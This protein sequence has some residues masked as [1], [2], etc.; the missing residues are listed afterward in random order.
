MNYFFSTTPVWQQKGLAIIR[1]ITGLFMVY[2]GWEVFDAGKMK[3]YLEWDQFQSPYSLFLVHLGKGSEFAG[4]LLLTLG[5]FTRW[6][7]LIIAVTMLYISLFVGTGKI[8]YQDQ[9]PFLF[10]L[11][12]LVFFFTGPGKYSIDHILFT[13]KNIT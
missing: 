1:I 4:G 10:V 13:K 6:A 2:H 7:C 9:H 11:L 5:L 8:W 12:A 3:T